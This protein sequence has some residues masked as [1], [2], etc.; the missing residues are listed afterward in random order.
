MWQALVT[1][2]WSW[3]VVDDFGF[4]LCGCRW[5]WIVVGDCEW[6]WMVVDGCGWF[7]GWFW[8]VMDSCGQL[9]VI[10]D[11]CGWFYG[12]LWMVVGS[13]GWLPVVVGGCGWLWMVAYFSI[14]HSIFCLEKRGVPWI[15][16][17]EFSISLKSKCLLLAIFLKFIFNQKEN[18]GL[19]DPK[20][21]I[22]YI[23]NIRIFIQRKELFFENNFS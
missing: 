4:F 19:L 16:I 23:K 9:W 1:F 7:F 2:A 8:M 15:T 18:R 20:L 10:V 17:P 22:F 3:I 11:G 12:W 14:T 21:S 5:L 6:L 13:C